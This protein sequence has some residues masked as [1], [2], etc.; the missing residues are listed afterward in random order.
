MKSI[1]V[2]IASYRDPELVPTIKDCIAK[3]KHP[4]R[5]TFGVCWQNSPDE[6]EVEDFLKSVPKLT[7][8]NVPHFSSRGLCWARSLIQKMY[9]GEDYTLQIDSHHRFVEGWDTELEHMVELTES[10]KPIIGSYCE[11]YYPL[12]P[13]KEVLK[14]PF[15]MVGKRF[16]PNGTIVFVPEVIPNFEKLTKPVRARFVSGHFFFTVGQHC[17]EYRYDPNIYFCGDEIS[18]SVRS[19]TLGYDLFHPYKHLLWHEY[20]RKLRVKHWD[21]FVLEN[22]K[23]G[24][25]EKMWHEIDKEGYVRLRQML[26]EEDNGLDLGEYDLGNV[27]SHKEYEDYAGINFA[28][29]VLHQNTMIGTEPPVNDSNEK[30]WNQVIKYNLQLNI[31]KPEGDF[32][33]I[34]VGIEDNSGKVLF[35]QDLKEYRE[36][37]NAKFQSITKPIKY[38]VWRHDTNGEWKERND[39]VF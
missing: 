6:S 31:P 26:R 27:R 2:Q 18:L 33:F 23:T 16:T 10:P 13:D 3:A 19:F 32:N 7:Y 28:N 17:E 20:S 1:F 21:D 9:K 24:K 12:E 5:L 38:V 39:F 4:E 35:R 36:K 11:Q 37:I 14:R 30:W 29:R 22:K 25:I 8:L 15:H 34:Y